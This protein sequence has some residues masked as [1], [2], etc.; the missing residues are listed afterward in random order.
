MFGKLALL[1]GDERQ[2]VMKQE[3]EARGWQVASWGLGGSRDDAAWKD[4]VAGAEAVLLPLPASADGVRIRCLPES[5]AVLR[6]SV[7][8]DA[9]EPGTKL[10][11]GKIPPLWREAAEAKGIEVSDYYESEVLQL[12]NALPTAEAALFLTMQELPVTLNGLS[13]AVVGYGRIGSLLAEK[14]YALG[15]SV[16]VY[17]RKPKDLAHAA[18]RHLHAVRLSGEGETSSLCRIPPDCRVIYNTAPCRILTEPVLRCLPRQCVLMELASAP[19]GFDPVCAERLGF[20]WILA[21]ALPGK[22]FPET[23]GKILAE[24]VS[25]LLLGNGS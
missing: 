12:R 14:L 16:T 4:A 15:A 22:H 25:D 18:L 13:V 17:A 19:G 3:L 23:A 2:K 5:G 7:L 9:M 24:T 10:L 1:G 6:Y 21:S 20:R 11:G 8:I